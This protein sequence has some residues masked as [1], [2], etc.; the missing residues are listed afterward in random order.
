VPWAVWVMVAVLGPIV[1][2]AL[3]W[4]G[5]YA[6]GCLWTR[7]TRRLSLGTESTGQKLP[8]ILE[9][10]GPLW[11]K[12]CLKAGGC[13]LQSAMKLP[14]TAAYSVPLH[15]LPGSTSPSSPHMS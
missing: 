13:T 4:P 5:V 1:A 3:P 15:R 10:C 9:K 8:N 14:V 12:E 2:R 6:I 11:L 7:L